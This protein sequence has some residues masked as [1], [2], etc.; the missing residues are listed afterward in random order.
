VLLEC[1]NMAPYRKPLACALDL[2]VHDILTVLAEVAPELRVWG[3]R[4]QSQPA[5]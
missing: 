5:A 1:T 2:P 3:P 4:H